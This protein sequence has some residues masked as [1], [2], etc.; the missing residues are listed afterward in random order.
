MPFVL[1]IQYLCEHK[2]RDVKNKWIL[3]VL[4]KIAERF[5]RFTTLTL[6][7]VATTHAT[8]A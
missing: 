3:Y 6:E 1:L 8:V 5:R 2:G 4:G 7:A